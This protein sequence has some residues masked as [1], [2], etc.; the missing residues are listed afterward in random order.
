MP[1]VALRDLHRTEPATKLTTVF[2]VQ[3]YWRD[4]TKL[5]RGKFQ[6]FGSMEAALRAG[7]AAADRAPRVE[8]FRWRGIAESDYCAERTVLATYGEVPEV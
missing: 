2:C 1:V 7:K 8:V 6:Q 5:V 3:A 4:R